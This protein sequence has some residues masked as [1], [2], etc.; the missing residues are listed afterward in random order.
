[1]TVV[2]AQITKDTEN[3]IEV[4]LRGT[5]SAVIGVLLRGL[6]VE[7]LARISE[8]IAIELRKSYGEAQS[9]DATR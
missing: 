1:M 4:V 6:P 2:E 3:T 5:S 7:G 8:A 9:A